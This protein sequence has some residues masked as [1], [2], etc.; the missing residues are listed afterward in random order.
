MGLSQLPVVEIVDT[1]MEIEIRDNQ[2]RQTNIY[3]YTY[4]LQFF[5]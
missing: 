3:V 5:V 2:N 4:T 1:L